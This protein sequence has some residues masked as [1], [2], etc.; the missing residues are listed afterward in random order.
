MTNSISGHRE[1]R[2]RNKKVLPDQGVIPVIIDHKT[3][4]YIKQGQDPE[5]RKRIHLARVEISRNNNHE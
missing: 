1:A 4:I 2:S 3:V 5:E